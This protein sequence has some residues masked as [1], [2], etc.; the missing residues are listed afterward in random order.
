MCAH[1]SFPL[2]DPFERILAKGF[3]LQTIARI[4][5]CLS[6]PSLHQRE[7]IGNGS[8]YHKN[9]YGFCYYRVTAPNYMKFSTR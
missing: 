2:K 4:L 7:M 3:K 8:Y 6:T 9:H 5:G 1:T